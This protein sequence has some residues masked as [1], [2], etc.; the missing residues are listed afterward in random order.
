MTFTVIDKLTGKP[1]DLKKIVLTEDWAKG[2]IH[3]D[4]QGFAVEEDETLLL[5]DECGK[6]EECPVDRFEILWK[7]K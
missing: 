7:S 5:L 1:P 3:C 6:Y 2:L 4:M